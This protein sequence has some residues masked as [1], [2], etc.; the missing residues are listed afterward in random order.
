MC[1]VCTSWL[2][3]FIPFKIFQILFHFLHLIFST[4]NPPLVIS[5]LFPSLITSLIFSLISIRGAYTDLDALQ[6]TN[7]H[8]LSNLTNYFLFGSILTIDYKNNG[9]DCTADPIWCIH[10]RVL[11][12]YPHFQ[13]CHTK[14]ESKAIHKTKYRFNTLFWIEIH[15]ESAK[16]YGSQL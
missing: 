11:W 6:L 8:E 13:T 15:A 14:L 9:Y 16:L 7:R 4:S 10:P 5:H 2:I 3:L 12:H 1:L